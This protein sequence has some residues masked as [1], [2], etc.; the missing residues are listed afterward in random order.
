MAENLE[1][2][3][4]ALDADPQAE[5]EIDYDAP[6]SGAFPPQV[7]PGRHDFIFK[8]AAEGAFGKVMVEGKPYLQVTFTAV[9]QGVEGKPDGV[10][11]NF[12]RASFFKHPKMKNSDGGELMRCLGIE[13]ESRKPSDIAAALQQADG[14]VRGTAVFGWKAYSKDTKEII[15]TNPRSK[16][17][18]NSG[19]KD[20]PWPKGA[21]GKYELVVRFPE[22]G[23]A[24][25]GRE[26]I[27][28]YKLPTAQ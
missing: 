27:V 14:R 12:Q 16:P 28:S 4:A 6:E 9:V 1:E 2:L 11:C 18:K 24:A 26:R 13:L 23:D 10:D 25:Y 17:R 8:L 21:D 19:K 15:S 22:S 7:Y 20:I 5:V 3:L